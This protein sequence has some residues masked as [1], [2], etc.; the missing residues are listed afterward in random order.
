MNSVIRKSCIIQRHIAKDEETALDLSRKACDRLF[1][2][3]N[4]TF[5]IGKDEIN[6]FMPR[7]VHRGAER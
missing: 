1:N 6:V 2:K 3:K 4:K 7:D 5:T